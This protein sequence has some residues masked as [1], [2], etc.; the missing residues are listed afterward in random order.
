MEPTVLSLH[1]PG[2]LTA[3]EAAILALRARGASLGAIVRYL[4]ARGVQ[5]SAVEISRYLRRCN[6]PAQ[7]EALQFSLRAETK[8]DCVSVPA[9]LAPAQAA[10][11][12]GAAGAA[13][14]FTWDLKQPKPE[15]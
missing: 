13:G 9:G 8:A 5:A 15:W 2:K 11:P 1:T 14:G 4:S 12:V 6:R 10:T 7:I 3:H